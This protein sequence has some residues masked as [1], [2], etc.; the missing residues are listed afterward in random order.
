VEWIGGLRGEFSIAVTA[1]D[2]SERE[3]CEPG[4][5]VDGR[6]S[7]FLGGLGLLLALGFDKGFVF[8]GQD[9]RAAQIFVG[10]K[11][12]F[13]LRLLFARSLLTRGFGYILGGLGA[14]LRSAQK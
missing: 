7:L 3:L 1:R 8:R 10:V 9:S 5:G 12:L 6:L 14:A 13:L 2:I 11:V 4:I